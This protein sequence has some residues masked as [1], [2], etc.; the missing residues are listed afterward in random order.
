MFKRNKNNDFF[1]KIIGKL[2]TALAVCELPSVT[3][4]AAIK[5]MG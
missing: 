4:Y 5:Y 3:L 2:Q 1:A